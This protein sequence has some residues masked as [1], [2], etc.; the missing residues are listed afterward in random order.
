MTDV[1]DKF[2][3]IL[4]SHT[5]KAGF[6]FERMRQYDGTGRPNFNGLFNFG[7]NAN[8]PLNTGNPFSNAMLGVFNSYTEATRVR[9]R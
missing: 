3:H 9:F 5:L 4:G 8:N 1:A 2:T 6:T 7:T